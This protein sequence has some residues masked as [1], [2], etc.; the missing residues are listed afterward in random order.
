[1]IIELF[2]PPGAGKT[3]FARALA[4]QLTREGR[5]VELILSLRPAEM[6]GFSDGAPSVRWPWA[7]VRRLARPAFALMTGLGQKSTQS[8]SQDFASQLLDLL[9]QSSVVGSLRLSQY[10]ARLENSWRLASKAGTTVIF[11]QGFVQC[12]CSLVLLAPGATPSAVDK[13]VALIPKA[14]Q[15]IMVQ[16]PKELLR[17]RLEARRNNQ[18]WFE[19]RL[20]LDVETSLRSIEILS[21]LESYLRRH[22][23]RITR[24]GPEENCFVR[25]CLTDAACDAETQI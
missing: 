16:A 20:E 11:D 10:I 9:P 6:A 21:T 4:E 1:M 8:R 22:G 17:A 18:S 3:T 2:G 15:W 14:D 19:R 13:G 5:P 12:L 25:A 7:A 24:I 23:T